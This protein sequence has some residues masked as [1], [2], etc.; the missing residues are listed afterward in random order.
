MRRW[1]LYSRCTGGA[2]R[3]RA[4]VLLWA[5]AVLVA[6]GLP[7][8]CAPAE[9]YRLLSFFFDGVPI[10]QELAGEFPELVVGPGGELMD[11]TDPRMQQFLAED[12][13]L[14]R[15][16]QI[17]QEDQE[18]FL[19]EPYDKRLCMECHKAQ[20]SFEAPITA[21]TCG[22]CHQSYYNP[23]PDE[24]VHGPVGLGR[25][26]M[27]HEPHESEHEGLLTD[28]VPELCFS[29]HD[30]PR[31]LSK[32]YHQEAK[33][34]PCTD[35]HDPHSAGNRSLIVDSNTYLR[36]KE[37]MP[38]LQSAHNDW[39]KDA[40]AK[41][42]EMERSNIIIPNVDEMCVSCHD[43]IREPQG[44]MELH[45]PVVEGQC[46][47]CHAAHDS[48]LPNLINPRAE[49]NCLECHELQELPEEA[50]RNMQRAECLTC[51]TGHQS[52]RGHLLKSVPPGE[53]DEPAPA[54]PEADEP[55]HE[56]GS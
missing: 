23:P 51:H 55:D 14:P 32:P 46:T 33:T 7:T 43:E 16:D 3:P 56:E 49:K 50:H 9:K 42:H 34:R 2:W 25:C 18:L 52:P 35:C 39:E 30:G 53:Q 26:G 20:A 15:P 11:P 13:V 45:D 29:C 22:Q 4:L 54:T 41:C 21:D 19:H 31:V 1:K 17:V 37:T 36:R 27:C 5:V 44:D 10:P 48:P 28:S 8:S 24:W 40:C 38:L 6:V 12:V 47:S